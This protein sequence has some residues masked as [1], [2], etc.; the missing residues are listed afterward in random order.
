[1]EN[2]QIQTLPGACPT[3]YKVL[4]SQADFAFALVGG[5]VALLC[6]IALIWNAYRSRGTSNSLAWCAVAILGLTGVVLHSDWQQYQATQ[7]ILNHA[8]TAPGT[9]DDVGRSEG[10]NSTL[11]GHYSFRYGR[12]IYHGFANLANLYPRLPKKDYIGKQYTVLF[13]TDN[14]AN[15][16]LDIFCPVGSAE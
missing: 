16:H 12:Y 8:A 2:W 1:L 4:Y 6:S 3:T 11:V 15:A 9:I 14:P 10:K 7:D 13:S 5:A